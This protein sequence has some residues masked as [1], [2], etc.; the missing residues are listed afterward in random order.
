MNTA[1]LICYITILFV[2]I[3]QIIILGGIYEE[4]KKLNRKQ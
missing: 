3:T 2:S 4:L 1:E